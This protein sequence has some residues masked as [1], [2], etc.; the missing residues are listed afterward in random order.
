MI[1][2][3]TELSDR[4]PVIV[5]V[6][7][8]ND[9]PA[10]PLEGMDPVA[11]MVEALR[12]AESDAGAPLLAHADALATVKQI[13]FPQLEDCAELVS[14]AIGAER[15]SVTETALPSGE[16]PVHLLNDAA[17]R[18]GAGEIEVALVCGGEALRTAAARIAAAEQGRRLDPV[19]EAKHRIRTG[20]A[21]RHGLVAP[22]DFYPL[23][24][25]AIRAAWGQ[26]LAEAQAE[27]GAIWSLL[28]Q[29]AAENPHAWTR[30]SKPAEEITALSKTN[31]PIAF[32]YTKLQVAN[33]A[34]NQGAGFIV[35][36]VGRARRLG[37][38]RSKWVF[39]G[40]GAGANEPEDVLARDRYDRSVSMEVAIHKALELNGVKARE[41]D[42]VELY[43]CFP[44]V[45]KM[46]RRVLDWPIDRPVS[47]FGGLTFGGGPVG[48]YMSHAIASMTDLLRAEGATG[49][50]FGNGG[51]ATRNHAIVLSSKP[52]EAAVFPCRYDFQNLADEAR[53]MVP[54]LSADYAGPATAETWTVFFNRDGSPDSGVVLARTPRAERTLARLTMEDC[55]LL[56]SDANNFPEPVGRSGEIVLHGQDRYW[57]FDSTFRAGRAES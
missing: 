9:R 27:T 10:D 11:L 5:G 17:N 34:V 33:S 54:A 14:V 47:P 51:I 40:N 7:Q 15:A 23:Y 19:R 36:S 45:P 1:T 49:L 35:A 13:S 29:I 6:G 44:C 48:N 41:L 26:T 20:H 16:S 52:I 4:L 50:L 18:I 2:S 37:I 3:P 24:E 32:P 31:R 43:S 57:R 22:V 28:S 55:A 53:A 46:A 30:E 25:N 38:P 21:A 39:V 8:V 42:A 56:T 12:R